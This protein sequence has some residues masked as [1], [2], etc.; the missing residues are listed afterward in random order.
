MATNQNNN[1]IDDG[2]NVAVDFVWGN[3]PMQPNDVRAENGGT[4]LDYTLDSH[5]IVEDGWNGYPLYTPN[6]A[7]SQTGGVD[8]ITVPN[9]LGSA[10]SDALALL[11][12]LELNTTATADRTNAAQSITDVDRTGGT[13]PARITGTGIVARYPIGSKITISGT[14]TVDGTFTVTDT[15]STN[16]I[17][18]LSNGN[19]ALSTGTGSV[20]GAVGSVVAQSI[21]AGQKRAAGTAMTVTAWA[22]AS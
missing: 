6:S 16:Q 7:G 5:N 15:A 17:Y 21:A 11:G 14:G 4:L 22:T 2:G 8:Y 10:K 19:T 9:V 13:Y 1:L 3:M 20:V 12:D 18:F